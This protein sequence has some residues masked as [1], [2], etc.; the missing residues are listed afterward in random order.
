MVQN[1][2]QK[3]LLLPTLNLNGPSALLSEKTISTLSLKTFQKSKHCY[4]QILRTF[5]FELNLPSKQ[6]SKMLPMTS[7]EFKWPWKLCLAFPGSGFNFVTQTLAKTTRK[8]PCQRFGTLAFELKVAS[9]PYS[10]I[11]AV[12]KFW[13]KSFWRI[14]VTFWANGFNFVNQKLVKNKLL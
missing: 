1:H 7:F 14:Y 9:K 4:F 2:F 6:F 8:C 3:C 10:K 5:A 12:I 11:L 13:I